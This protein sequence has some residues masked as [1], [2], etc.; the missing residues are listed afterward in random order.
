MAFRLLGMRAGLRNQPRVKSRPHHYQIEFS[1]LSDFDLCDTFDSWITVALTLDWDD[2]SYFSTRNRTYY[3]LREMQ[4][5]RLPLGKII[6]Q[7]SSFGEVVPV[8]EPPERSFES[9]LPSHKYDFRKRC[10][11]LWGEPNSGKIPP[12]PEFEKEDLIADISWSSISSAEAQQAACLC[13]AAPV[14]RHCGDV[15]S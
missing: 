3:L 10:P 8:H 5:R 1:R 14:R 4:S 11:E 2:Y 7:H 12:T 15:S 6:F 9:D 13:P